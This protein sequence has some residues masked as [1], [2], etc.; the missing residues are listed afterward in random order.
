[1]VNNNTGTADAHVF[2]VSWNT[3]VSVHT[4]MHWEGTDREQEMSSSSMDEP[5]VLWRTVL[6]LDKTKTEL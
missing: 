4:T 2:H 6:E 3:S 1:M 5:D